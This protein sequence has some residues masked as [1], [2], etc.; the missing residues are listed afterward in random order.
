V[1]E[2][3][4]PRTI[5]E[6]REEEMTGDGENYKLRSFISKYYSDQIEDE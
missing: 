1:F 6:H 4:L 2:N 3:K 5:F